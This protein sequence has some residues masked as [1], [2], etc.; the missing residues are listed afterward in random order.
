MWNDWAVLVVPLLI[1][2]L[3]SIVLAYTIECLRQHA[4]QRRQRHF[5]L[6][7]ISMIR[8]PSTSNAISKDY[9]GYEIKE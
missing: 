9:V 2:L 8:V 1:V 7:C 3:L 6:T 5:Q 4:I